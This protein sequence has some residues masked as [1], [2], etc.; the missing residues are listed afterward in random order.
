MFCMSQR[1]NTS[2]TFSTHCFFFC[3]CGSRMV[4]LFFLGEELNLQQFYFFCVLSVEWSWKILFHFVLGT[5]SRLRSPSC[6]VRVFVFHA[7]PSRLLAASCTPVVWLTM[8]NCT[9][10]YML[11]FQVMFAVRLAMHAVQLGLYGD[12]LMWRL[13]STRQVRFPFHGGKDWRKKTFT[14]ENNRPSNERKVLGFGF[15]YLKHISFIQS[16]T[17]DF[18]RSVSR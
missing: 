5:R 6:Y 1:P 12:A 16:N 2:S 17:E 14:P 15:G 3:A 9:N 8:P 11:F 10:I 13:T 18:L 7:P 4:L